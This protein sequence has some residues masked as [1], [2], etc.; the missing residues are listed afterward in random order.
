MGP[1]AWAVC[2]HAHKALQIYTNHICRTR[3]KFSQRENA[4][5]PPQAVALVQPVRAQEN[6]YGRNV[7]QC[8]DALHQKRSKRGALEEARI[9]I[10]TDGDL[11]DCRRADHQ[12][13]KEYVHLLVLT[14]RNDG[15]EKQ[16]ERFGE[17][18]HQCGSQYVDGCSPIIALQ[19][20]G[21]ASLVCLPIKC[22]YNFYFLLRKRDPFLDSF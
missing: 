21:D 11:I 4:T 17:R 12:V 16:E 3:R 10:E 6:H 20:T 7:R 19:G 1:M 15:Q 8:R 22:I 2:W 9:E 18:A 14:A 5:G 13:G